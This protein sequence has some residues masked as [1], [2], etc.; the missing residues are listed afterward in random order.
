MARGEASTSWPSPALGKRS[1]SLR[2][3]NRSKCSRLRLRRSH[4]YLWWMPPADP[5]RRRPPLPR[6][7]TGGSRLDPRGAAGHRRLQQPARLLRL[8]LCPKQVQRRLEPRPKL[9]HGCRLPQALRRGAVPWCGLS[10][11]HGLPPGR[12][13]R[14]MRHRHARSYA[15][16]QDYRSV[17]HGQGARC[18]DPA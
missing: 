2:C 5:G 10:D 16:L 8:P 13:Q 14:K 12:M 3:P 7:H 11:P 4:R 18:P 15:L 1:Q 17:G 6:G 9:Q